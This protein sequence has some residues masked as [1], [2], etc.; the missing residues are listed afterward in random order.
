[1]AASSAGTAGK[2]THEQ[3]HTFVFQRKALMRTRSILGLG[4]IVL[5]ASVLLAGCDTAGYYVQALRGQAEIWSATRP[6]EEVIADPATPGVLR[7]RLAQLVRIREFAVEDLRLPDNSSYRGYADLRRPYVVWNVF[8]TDPLSIRLRQWCFPV[9]GC[10]SYRGY[11]RRAD[12]EA[13]AEELR[14]EGHEVFVGGVPAYSTLGYLNDPVLNTFIRYPRPELARLVF[15]ELAHQIAYVQDDTIF[16]ESFA[17]AVEREGV[18]RWLHRHGSQSELEAF[19]RSQ[20]RRS[21]FLALTRKYRVRL[22]RLYASGLPPE[23]MHVRKQAVFA[24]LAQEYRAFKDAWGGFGGYD[25]WL[26]ADA[27]NASLAS[28]GLYTQLVPAFEDLLQAADHDL[29][30]FYA[31]VKRLAQLP[32][33]ERDARLRRVGASRPVAPAG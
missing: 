17:V 20:Q 14:R 13:Y 16:N 2:G 12:A 4:P 10:V 1:M 18:R 32:R 3:R 11:F 33:D 7:D 27:N 21:A 31:E 6:I 5:G 29:P 25:R 8:A 15:H 23:Q 30:R 22:E 26:G 19:R 9:A 28:V 24:E